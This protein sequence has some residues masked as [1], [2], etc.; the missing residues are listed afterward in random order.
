MHIKDGQTTVLNKAAVACADDLVAGTALVAAAL[1]QGWTSNI[2]HVF[3]STLRGNAA[4]KP[5]P[6]R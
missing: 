1:D 3:V 4:T 6:P 5:R 2:Q